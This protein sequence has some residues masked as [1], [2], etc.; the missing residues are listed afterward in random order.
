MVIDEHLQRTGVR[1]LVGAE[2]LDA[3]LPFLEQ[4]VYLFDR[5]GNL[6]ARLSPPGGLLGYDAGAGSNIFAHLH[7]DDLPRGMRFG[8]RGP[9]GWEGEAVVRLRH[10]DGGWRHMHLRV[11]DRRN[12]PA[13]GGTVVTLR[14]IAAELHATDPDDELLA[15]AGDLPTAYLALGD[16]GR[17][18]FASEA[19]GELLRCRR[20]DLVGL[21]V[22][23][24]VV[25]ADRPAVLAAYHALLRSPGARTVV[26]ATRARF[27]GRVLEAELHTRSDEDHK[28][29]TVVLV[30]R[31]EEPELVRL[32]TRDALTGLANRTKV[33]ETI[34]GLLV[35]PEPVLS[36][37]YVDLDDLKVINDRHGHETGDRALIEVAHHLESMVR[38]GDVV[39]RMSGD[40]FVIVCP[41]MDGR[42]LLGFVQRVG[43]ARAEPVD[44]PD[45]TAVPVSVS[46]GGATAVAGDTTATVL[47]RADE[48]MFAAKHE[49]NRRRQ[50]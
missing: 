32:A 47:R 15:I 14:E 18:R 19:A 1:G 2:H 35:D 21:P 6:V 4:A 16:G 17:V 40:E 42:G 22:G 33:L 41:G 31:S 3:L 36:V 48:A 39:G 8:S 25:D 7:P 43:D 24:L 45:G 34:A 30:D 49:R 27:G 10:A 38:P 44:A 23:D 29:V 11:F 28:L 9:A 12:D 50:R 5:D 46:A 20:D 37:V 13:I 26:T